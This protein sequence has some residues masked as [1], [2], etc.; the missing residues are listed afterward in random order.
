[1]MKKYL[2]C[3]DASLAVMWSIPSQRTPAVMNL[4]VHWDKKSI[5]LIA[6]PLFNP[7]VTSTIRLNVFF[8]K[9]TPEEGEKAFAGFNDLNVKTINHPGLCRKAWD[10]AKLYN[11]PR[12]YDMQYLALAELEDCELWTA[13][14]RLI[15]SLKG[16]NQRVHRVEDYEQH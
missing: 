4:L 14:I 2:V 12:T 1:M 7:E 15:N 5:D 11:L 6:P 8:K 9:M 16:L 3:V 10:L 13:D